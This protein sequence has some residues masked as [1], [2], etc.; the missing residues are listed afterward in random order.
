MLVSLNTVYLPI[1]LN[2]TINLD[3]KQIGFLIA[4]AGLLKVFSNYFINKNIRTFR[5]RKLIA[6]VITF[7]LL[8]SFILISVLKSLDFILIIILSF[9]ILII[10]SPILPLVEN[11]TTSLNK[12]FYKT[13]GKLRISG[14][15]AFCLAVFIVGFILDQ[16]GTNVLPLLYI[17]FALFFL[18][19]IYL[20]PSKEKR[21]KNIAKSNVSELLTDKIFILVLFSCSII[22]ASHAMYYSF[23]AI[24]WREYNINL[25]QVGF[26][27]FWG[28]LAE[29]IFFIFID[30]VKIKN[31]F[32]KA[33]I[34]V[35]FI[36][37][38]RWV[39]TFLFTNF[40]ILIAIQSLHA[41]TFGLTHYLV[42][43]YIYKKISYNNQLLALSLYHAL[44]SGIIMTM[45]TILAGFSFNYHLN[46]LG[47]VV[48]AVFSF[49]S[50]ILIYFRGYI[51]KNERS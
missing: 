43:Y 44:S 29:I 26:L 11:I 40:F 31:I 24:Y 15:I 19:S 10:F 42:I 41:F 36:T 35:A 37:S 25:F 48:M 18:L 46:G 49:F 23:S 7:F 16:F 34:L 9:L 32:F 33:I 20:V 50:I 1:W 28:V 3:V 38:L 4:A 13:Y 2:E 5:D 14:S 6:I 30:K 39:L 45:L 21:K 17:I 51:L 47:F 22:L 8:I 12:N 27:W